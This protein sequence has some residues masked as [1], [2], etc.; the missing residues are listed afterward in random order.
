MTYI[1]PTIIAMGFPATGAEAMYRNRLED[2]KQFLDS[3]HPDAYKVINLCSERSYPPEK[4]DNRCATFPFEDHNAPPLTYFRPFCEYV[5][6]HLKSDPANVVAVHCKAGKGRT[7]VMISAYLLFANLVS[8]AE[9][10]L[11]LFDRVRTADGKGVTIPSQRRYVGYWE[12]LLKD[13]NLR[14]EAPATQILRTL[15]VIGI[16]KLS[17]DGSC[18]PHFEVVVNRKLVYSSKCVFPERKYVAGKDTEMEF[19]DLPLALYGDVKIQFFHKGE[20]AFH[21]WF[22]TIFV[23]EERKMTFTQPELDK[24]CKDTSHKVYPENFAVSMVFL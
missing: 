10:A 6:A 21:F 19:D 11:Y 20:K 15:K 5:D 16:P 24:A 9:E 8:T 23:P 3:Y 2:V 14:P 17:S 18:E 12:L 13:E 4:F 7:G 22:N 1:S